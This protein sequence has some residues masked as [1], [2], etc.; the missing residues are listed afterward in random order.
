MGKVS[1]DQSA[2]C[3]LIQKV[4]KAFP[5]H[6]FSSNFEGPE[7]S[8][9]A[10]RC[11]A[12]D[13]EV[14]VCKQ[15]QQTPLGISSCKPKG[16][17]IE[18]IGQLKAYGVFG[19][20]RLHQARL[21]KEPAIVSQY[22]GPDLFDYLH[23]GPIG[24]RILPARFYLSVAEHL[25]TTLH[26]LHQIPIVHGDVRLENITVGE[27]ERFYLIDFDRC[28]TDLTQTPPQSPMFCR[29]PEELCDGHRGPLADLW[30]LGVLLFQGYCGEQ[31]LPLEDKDLKVP[32]TLKAISF[33]IGSPPLHYPFVL[34]FQDKIQ[35]VKVAQS[36]PDMVQSLREAG[37][38][39]GDIDEK[40]YM[41]G[42]F[43]TLWILL[44]NLLT[45]T[46]R[47]SARE[48]LDFLRQVE[49]N[50]TCGDNPNSIKIGMFKN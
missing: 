7:A 6:Q 11:Y 40:G 22:G 10:I 37:K 16:P 38:I 18:M 20:P 13:Q 39:N 4:T 23:D 15:Y 1:E 24:K 9:S 17:L 41:S 45:Y 44:A 50:K 28:I 27:G 19:I 8:G 32:L 36:L 34:R 2:L 48:A 21:G 12:N 5:F 14:V 30:G 43:F 26:Q 47:W 42:D 29:S 49:K 35:S 25:L 3:P 31:F 46:N 33:R